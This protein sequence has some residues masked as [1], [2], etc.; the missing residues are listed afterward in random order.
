MCDVIQASLTCKMVLLGTQSNG[1]VSFCMDFMCHYTFDVHGLFELTQ[2]N[3]RTFCFLRT[4]AEVVMMVRN[5]K[6]DPNAFEPVHFRD[7]Q[8]IRRV[9]NQFSIFSYSIQPVW[10]GWQARYTSTILIT[11]AFC[12]CHFFFFLLF[13][14]VW[15]R[16]FKLRIS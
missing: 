11:A 7:T 9:A 4:E 1:C 10:N 6:C 12:L 13:I 2:P 14:F 5:H 16:L 3:S 15:G 8:W